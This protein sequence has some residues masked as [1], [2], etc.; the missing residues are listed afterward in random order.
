MP[1]KTT[2]KTSLPIE[3]VPL[4]KQ[5][6]ITQT[7]SL[8]DMIQE[9]I[10]S[11]RSVEVKRSDEEY[12]IVDEI[13]YKGRLYFIRDDSDVYRVAPGISCPHSPIVCFKTYNKAY[14][15]TQ[16]KDRE[17]IELIHYLY[18][19]PDIKRDH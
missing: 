16:E 7:I 19:N 14:M 13:P 5:K 3:D 9:A 18:K 4:P 17:I 15:F 10:R 1:R 2:K 6:P 11:N 12:L 8:E